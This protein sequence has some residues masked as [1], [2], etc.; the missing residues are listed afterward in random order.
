MN[1]SVSRRQLLQAAGG[2][3][4]SFSVNGKLAAIA[5]LTGPVRAVGP[6]RVDS[7]LSIASDGTVTTF[8]GK[9][10]MGTGVRTAFAQI[11][12]EELD[13]AFDLVRVVMGDTALTPDQ[14]K[15]TASQN[16]V[17][18]V[19]PLRIAAAEARATLL[20]LAAERMGV[21]VTA[22]TA[23]NGMV[24]PVS[25]SSG[26]LAYA[27]L[28]K[29]R[30]FSIDLEIDRQTPW[31]PLLKVKAPLKPVASYSI[32]GQP[33]PRAD[34]PGK[35]TGTLEYVQN[36]RVPGM[37]HGRAIRPPTIGAKLVSVDET[38]V[39]D[40][41]SA[42]VVRRGDFL[43]VVA[44]RE[45]DAI[46]ASRLLKAEWMQSATLPDQR[47][48]Y[49]S[50]RA[51]GV[52]EEQ[53]ERPSGDVDAGFAKAKFRVKSNYDFAFQLHAI[54][55]PSCAVADV[56]KDQAVICGPDRNGHRAIAAILPRCS[57]FRWSVCR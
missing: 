2:L 32:V 43:A 40:I 57:A 5:S 12:A 34:V 36:V 37:L 31:G 7:W 9:I 28:L 16:I 29:D 39:R 13:V 4:V 47:D 1:M 52:V 35:V 25:S 6:T 10:D 33:I 49:R 3:V 44:E 56:R 38:A 51:A 18:G 15:S 41:S 55:G 11:V 27:D 30:L 21:S 19:E 17:T 14:G 8:T 42:R 20:R 24:R 26:G 54:I 23:A 22:L 46:R 53:K 45:E 48:L 50:L